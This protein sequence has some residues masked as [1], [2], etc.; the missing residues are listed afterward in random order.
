MWNWRF[1]LNLLA[2]L[3]E[4]RVSKRLPSI[5][6][7]LRK[8]C[9]SGT[10]VPVMGRYQLIALFRTMQLWWRSNLSLHWRYYAEAC[11]EFGVGGAPS[12][13]HCACK[14]H[15]FLLKK[16]CKSGKLLAAMCPIW[17]VRDLNVKPPAPEMNTLPL[18]RNLILQLQISSKPKS[19]FICLSKRLNPMWMTYSK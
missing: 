4:H 17:P 6:I 10:V 13:R 2:G 5:A 15:I 11:N 19:H 9:C 8:N 3:I 7:S 16:C 12:T 18:D 1:R 14:Q